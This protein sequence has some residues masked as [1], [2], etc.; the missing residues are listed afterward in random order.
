MADDT[1]AA[2]GCRKPERDPSTAAREPRQ[3]KKKSS[4]QPFEI[5]SILDAPIIVHQA[6]KRK[7]LSATEVMIRRLA[8][9]AVSGKD[10]RATIEFLE[11]CEKHEL[12]ATP[13][14][15]GFRSVI[16][17]PNDAD[18]NDY[19]EKLLRYGPQS[20]WPKGVTYKTRP[21]RIVLGKVEEK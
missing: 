13:S 17:V 7:K 8:Q 12:I 19:V 6:G 10:L 1:S 11:L 18:A 16:E 5:C 9:K 4:L 2:N 15:N 14:D 3:P 20:R 21:W